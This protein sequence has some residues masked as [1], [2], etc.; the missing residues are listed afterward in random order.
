MTT[1][2]ADPDRA[3]PPATLELFPLAPAEEAERVWVH[4]HWRTQGGKPVYVDGHW[5]VVG[6]RKSRPKEGS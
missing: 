4:G 5:R 6:A 3:V 2:P 1:P